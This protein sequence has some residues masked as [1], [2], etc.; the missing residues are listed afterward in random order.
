MEKRLLPKFR[1]GKLTHHQTLLPVI[2]NWVPRAR[3]FDFLHFLSYKSR[4]YL[5]RHYSY[6]RQVETNQGQDYRWLLQ[7]APRVKLKFRDDEFIRSCPKELLM[8]YDNL[9][10]VFLDSQ[11]GLLYSGGCQ[12][13]LVQIDL[14]TR[15]IP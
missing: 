2:L 13:A 7:S 3:K 12:Q 11:R 4:E 1:L 8:Y 6:I 10:T 5:A 9:D 15:Q 14:A